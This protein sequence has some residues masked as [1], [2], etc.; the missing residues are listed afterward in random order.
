MF[1]LIDVET[2]L[3]RLEIKVSESGV[4]G[5]LTS[6]HGISNGI[7]IKSSQ[8]ESLQLRSITEGKKGNCTNYVNSDETFLIS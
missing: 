5:R 3:I 4:N 2:I 6:E 1:Q 7:L 8:S